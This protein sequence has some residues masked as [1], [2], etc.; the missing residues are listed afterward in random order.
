MRVSIHNFAVLLMIINTVNCGATHKPWR[1]H[2][3]PANAN[4]YFIPKR[5]ELVLSCSVRPFVRQCYCHPLMGFDIGMEIFYFHSEILFPFREIG[6]R[7]RN[8]F[9]NGNRIEI[10]IV[11]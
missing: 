6:M 11:I 5:S 1:R 2:L 4:F 3:T 9:E 10:V 8:Y 7:I